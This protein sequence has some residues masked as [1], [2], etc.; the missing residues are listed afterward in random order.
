M[1]DEIIGALPSNAGLPI[2]RSVI[3]SVSRR[4]QLSLQAIIHGFSSTSPNHGWDVFS[5]VPTL[6]ASR[7]SAP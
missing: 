2:A 6:W 4:D 1:G 7:S 5:D 3:G